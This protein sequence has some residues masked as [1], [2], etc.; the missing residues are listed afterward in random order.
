MGDPAFMRDNTQTYYDQ[1]A[2]CPGPGPQG[3][4]VLSPRGPRA[5]WR[6][7]VVEAAQAAGSTHSPSAELDRGTGSNPL[8]LRGP[9]FLA[10]NL[11][12]GAPDSGDWDTIKERRARTSEALPVA[13]NCSFQ[14]CLYCHRSPEGVPLTL[15]GVACGAG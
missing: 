9:P 2:A 5:A 3:P 10:M 15:L 11:R 8:S 12:G 13:F 1:Q 7:G 6:V 4:L 14:P